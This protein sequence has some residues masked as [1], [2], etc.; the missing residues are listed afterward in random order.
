MRV[1]RATNN[2]V[3]EVNSSVLSAA[4]ETGFETKTFY[5]NVRVPTI[6]DGESGPDFQARI[7][8]FKAQVDAKKDSPIPKPQ[9]VKPPLARIEK[10]VQEFAK[11]HFGK[12]RTATFERWTDGD[13]VP[14]KGVNVD[15]GDRTLEATVTVLEHDENGVSVKLV[16]RPSRWVVEFVATRAKNG[17]RWKFVRADISKIELD[18]NDKLCV[19]RLVRWF[20]A[21]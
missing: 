10:A 8:A 20:E 3:C 14:G 16:G 15:L 4:N 12:G 9:P 21:I 11:D 13:Y 6:Q 17:N 19:D 1:R 5:R 7:A 2:G 18:P